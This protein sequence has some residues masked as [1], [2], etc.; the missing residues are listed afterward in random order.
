M[1]PFVAGE[2]LKKD[3]PQVEQAVYAWD[4]NPVFF[5]NGQ[6]TTTKTI[7]HRRRISST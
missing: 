6:A 4:N 2:A 5:Q 7:S 1:T 3:F